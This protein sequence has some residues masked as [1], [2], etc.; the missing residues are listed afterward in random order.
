MKLKLLK[1][2]SLTC[3]LE[4]SWSTYDLKESERLNESLL[5]N[6]QLEYLFEY[7]SSFSDVLM[8]VIFLRFFTGSL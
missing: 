8:T 7:L 1:D 5:I 4:K 3:H 2:F 6:F